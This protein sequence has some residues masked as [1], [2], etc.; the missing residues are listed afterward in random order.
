MPNIL[1]NRRPPTIE[2][3]R[4]NSLRKTGERCR[5]E[6]GLGLV[7]TIVVTIKQIEHRCMFSVVEWLS[8]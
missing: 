7:L 5:L 6:L 3:Q 2:I 4:A 1:E 8:G